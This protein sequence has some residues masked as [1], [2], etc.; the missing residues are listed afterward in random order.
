[1]A[2][3]VI[4]ANSSAGGQ[5][6]QLIRTGDRRWPCRRR[7]HWANGPRQK[8]LQPQPLFIGAELIRSNHS[9]PNTRSGVRCIRNH[10]SPYH[11]T[12]R[13]GGEAST[14]LSRPIRRLPGA[15]RR[16]RTAGQVALHSSIPLRWL[17]GTDRPHRHQSHTAG[18]EGNRRA[19]TIPSRTDGGSHH[20][21]DRLHLTVSEGKRLIARAVAA[22]SSHS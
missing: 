21:Q 22:R 3:K 18:L 12:R 6:Q 14:W 8:R 1:M 11:G 19:L 7:T 20:G 15:P 10:R 9:S 17:E 4:H 5:T 2:T 13:S 16:F